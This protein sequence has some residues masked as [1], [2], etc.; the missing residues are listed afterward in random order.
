MK[1]MEKV[2]RALREPFP[3]KYLSWTVIATNKDSGDALVSPYVGRH[4]IMARFDDVLGPMNW[5]TGVQGQVGYLIK[6]IGIRFEKSEEWVWRWE[7]G[8]YIAATDKNR[9]RIEVLGSATV[10][11]RRAAIEWG[12]GRYLKFITAQWVPYDAHAKKI[13]EEPR[14]ENITNWWALPYDHPVAAEKW[15][16]KNGDPIED[17]GKD[18]DVL[19]V[20]EGE[21]KAKHDDK[22]PAEDEETYGKNTIDL[23][24]YFDKEEEDPAEIAKEKAKI[25]K[26]KADPSQEYDYGDVMRMAIHEMGWNYDK[27]NKYLADNREKTTPNQMVAEFKAAIKK[28]LGIKQEA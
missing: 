26:E 19:E 2:F 17:L 18:D 6:G 7:P 21:S 1:T 11:L 14:I 16:T 9:R 28:G 27:A 20:V 22:K 3:V 24:E 4:H 10:G 12:V 15:A 23:D 13:R 8:V 5:Q 25:A